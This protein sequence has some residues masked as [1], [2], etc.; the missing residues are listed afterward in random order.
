[1]KREYAETLQHAARMDELIKAHLAVMDKYDPRHR[2]SLLVDEWGVWTDPEPGS[3]PGFLY[4]Q[5][6]LRDVIAAAMGYIFA[7][8]ASRIGWGW[9]TLRRW[10]MYYRR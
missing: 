7:E 2:V 1:M 4:Q 8:T 9:R 5:N 3:T 10:S 6:T